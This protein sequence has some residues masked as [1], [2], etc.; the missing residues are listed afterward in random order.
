MKIIDAIS[1][2]MMS[3]CYKRLIQLLLFKH[4]VPLVLSILTTRI[5]I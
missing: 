5:L 3:L 1:T 4:L 2:F